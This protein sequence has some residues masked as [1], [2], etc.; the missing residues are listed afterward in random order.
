MFIPAFQGVYE[1]RFCPLARPFGLQ[2]STLPR[3]YFKS[4]RRT[5]Q[6]LENANMVSSC[7]VFLANPLVLHFHIYELTLDLTEGVLD[8][9]PDA[10]LGLF[11]RLEMNGH[12][13]HVPVDLRMVLDHFLVLVYV[14]AAEVGEDVVFLSLPQLAGLGKVVHVGR[15]CLGGVHQAQVGIDTNMRLH[16]EAPLVEYEGNSHF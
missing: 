2:G 13:C 15:C 1:S 10:R 12:H 14:P 4:V 5:I 3:V 6:M 9:S 16:P 11:Q 8:L 7:A